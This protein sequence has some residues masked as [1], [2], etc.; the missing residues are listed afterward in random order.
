MAGGTYL[1]P[2]YSWRHSA[3]KLARSV[4]IS[5]FAAFFGLLSSRDRQVNCYSEVL[6]VPPTQDE[7]ASQLHVSTKT[8]V[9]HRQSIMNKLGLR[10]VAE[11]TK[12]AVRMGL[13]PLDG[14]PTQ[15]FPT[16]GASVE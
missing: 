16:E 4:V 6:R 14:R 2:E 7:I 9:W 10:S 3:G 1:S 15:P 12:F 5:R 11:L 13:T 8:I